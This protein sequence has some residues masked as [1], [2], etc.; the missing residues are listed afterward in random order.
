MA[1]DGTNAPSRHDKLGES[2]QGMSDV[3]SADDMDGVPSVPNQ[4]NQIMTRG[5][6]ARLRGFSK[7][8][9]STR[10]CRTGRGDHTKSHEGSTHLHELNTGVEVRGGKKKHVLPRFSP[11]TDSQRCVAI[12]RVNS[13]HFGMTANGGEAT[14]HSSTFSRGSNATLPECD[15]AHASSHAV[16]PIHHAL[17]VSPNMANVVSSLIDRK[18]RDDC[19]F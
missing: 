3:S 8:A 2:R 19:L 13:R 9:L 6:P 7:L 18:M 15:S 11:S 10:T 17:Q 12:V 4:R 16:R 14:G 1:S 5:V